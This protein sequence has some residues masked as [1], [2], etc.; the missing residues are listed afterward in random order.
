MQMVSK[1]MVQLTMFQ[2]YDGME[3][4]AFRRSRTSNFEIGSFPRQA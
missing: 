1:L 3:S 2:V 4:C